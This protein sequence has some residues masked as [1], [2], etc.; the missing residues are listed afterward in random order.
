[1]RKRDQCDFVL[2]LKVTKI[3]NK[4]VTVVIRGCIQRKT[5]CM[6][7]YAVVDHKASY[8]LVNSVVS[9]RIHRWE[10]TSALAKG[11]RTGPPGYMGWRAGMKTPQS[12]YFT[13]DETG[14]SAHSAGGYTATLLVM[15]NVMKGVGCA[16]PTLTSL[17]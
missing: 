1:M 13:K 7:P 16:P 6:G 5:W 12:T 9:S 11:C 15:A 3:I 17:G 10:I 2:S 14:L 4:A 8:L